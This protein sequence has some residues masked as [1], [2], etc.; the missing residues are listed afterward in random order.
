MSDILLPVFHS[1]LSGFRTRADLQLE[2]IALRHQ[3]KVLRRNRRTRP[4]L[5]RLDRAFW[6]LFYRL[7]SRCLDAVIIVKPDTVVRW[8]RQGFRA[9][10]PW[11]S[12]RRGRGRP[13][14]AAN[15]KNLIR[16]MSRE[17][18]LWGA[19][20]IHGELL[21]LGIEISQAVVSKYMV[22]RPRPP[23]QSWR[24]FLRN[25]LCCLASV[26]FFVVPTATFRLLFVF[27]VLQHERRR[28]VHFSVTTQP[29]SVW[30]AQQ[31]REAFPWDKAPRYQIRDR[32]ASYGS[33]FRSRLD[34]MGICDVPT[35]PRSPWQNAC[36]ERL[37]G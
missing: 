31:I 12:R 30:A 16:R 6:I 37:I 23:S 18:R 5:T 17:N 27:V 3:L 4:R 1:F 21:K 34:A 29:T 26:D 28:I 8:H 13:P 9:F 32:D 19:P 35:A 15:I 22:H 20:R 36:V 14:L 33:V 2:V 7:W 10:W 11:K 25:H 24:T